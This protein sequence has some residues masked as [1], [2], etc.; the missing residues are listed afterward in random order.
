M[1]VPDCFGANQ[2]DCACDG[3]VNC[4]DSDYGTAVEIKNCEWVKGLLTSVDSSG[5][6]DSNINSKL[7]ILE[8]GE[9]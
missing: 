7:R 1:K 9:I 8:F 6:A 4:V 5:C 2:F 3:N